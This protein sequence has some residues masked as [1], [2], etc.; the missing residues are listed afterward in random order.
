VIDP[1]AASVP[2]MDA[3]AGRRMQKDEVA[4][5]VPVVFGADRVAPEDSVADQVALAGPRRK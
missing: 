5:S 1:V 4:H 2:K 3:V